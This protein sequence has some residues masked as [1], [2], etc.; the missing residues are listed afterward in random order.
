MWSGRR[1]LSAAIAAVLLIGVP[2]VAHASGK[3]KKKHAAGV[4][5]GALTARNNPL[6]IQVSRD[7]HEVVRAAITFAEKCTQGGNLG[8]DFYSHVPIH[9]NG[10]A[11]SSYSNFRYDNPDGTY[12][13]DAGSLRVVMNRRQTR[14]TGT[15]RFSWTYHEASGALKDTCD[16]GV[17]HVDAKQ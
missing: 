9:A 15:A 7:R 3:P 16:S 17:V 14:M 2:V 5:F 8:T 1:M 6:V 10:H 11:S 12:F 13:I 4:M